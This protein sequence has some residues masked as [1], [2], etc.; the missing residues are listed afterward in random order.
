MTIFL[1]GRGLI[2]RWP[3]TPFAYANCYWC[4]NP[5][6]TAELAS[7]NIAADHT[8]DTLT[9]RNEERAKMENGEP[10]FR[11]HA[12]RRPSVRSSMSVGIVFC[13]SLAQLLT[14]FPCSHKTTQAF[15]PHRF[16][17]V[18][19]PSFSSHFNLDSNPP[20][21]VSAFIQADGELRY[22]VDGVSVPSLAE[23][24]D[25][26]QWRIDRGEKGGTLQSGISVE[27]AL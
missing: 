12:D 16:L 8:L 21:R 14:L 19:S 10:D 6:A 2:S 20:S 27:I 18:L 23:V 9:L 5:L 4:L 22:L 15:L 11:V 3:E 7:P 26:K 1:Q 24:S 13:R 25:L 17:S